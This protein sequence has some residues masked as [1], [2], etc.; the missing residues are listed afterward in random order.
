MIYDDFTRRVM[1]DY[2]LYL[3]A[4]TGRYQGIVSP[5]IAITP[6]VVKEFRR[7]AQKFTNTFMNT[8]ADKVDKYADALAYGS[9]TDK[10]D[11]DKAALLLGISAASQENVA[12]VTKLL[13]VGALNLKQVLKDLHGTFGLLWQKQLGIVDFKI[14][15][16]ANRKWGAEKLVK[17]VVHYFA[18]NMWIDSQLTE[19]Q[20]KGYKLAIVVYDDQEARDEEV[21]F[22]ISEKVE[23][24]PTLG[25]IRASVFHPNA[26][27]KV[28]PY[29]HS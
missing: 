21:I 20:K 23:G 26:T 2:R 15:D 17:L 4:L 25:Q 1:D 6:N 14:Y 9:A 5:G 13:R 16:T 24:Y 18:Y 3:M 7:D 19:F 10:M 11:N 8:L 27:A 28:M 12:Q 22:S 29:V